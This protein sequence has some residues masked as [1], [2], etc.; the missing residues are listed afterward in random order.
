LSAGRTQSFVFLASRTLTPAAEAFTVL[1]RQVE[2]EVEER[3]RA[4][5]DE[6]FKGLKPGG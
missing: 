3:N 6:A 2:H 1:V 4:L 5:A